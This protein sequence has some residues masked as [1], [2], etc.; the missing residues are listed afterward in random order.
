MKQEIFELGKDSVIYGV[1]SVA[2]RFVGLITL[3]LFTAYL[4]PEEYGVLAM[5]ALLGMVA[6]PVFSLGLSAAM[7][8]SYFEKDTISNKSKTVWSVF[9]INMLSVF[10]LIILAWSFPVLF[11]KFVRLPENYSFLVSLSLT[12][13]A[14]TILVTSF[15]QRIQFERQARLY[16]MITVATALAAILTSIYTVVFLGWGVYGMVYGQVAGNLITFLAFFAV[17]IR[18]TFPTISGRIIKDLLKLGLPFV[19]SFAFLFILMHVNKYILEWRYGLDAVGVYSIG[20]NLG[21][22][23]SIITGGITTAWFPFYMRY[24]DKQLEATKIFGKLFSYYIIGVGCLTLAFFIFARPMVMLLTN[25]AF[26]DSYMVVGLVASSLYFSG[27]YSFLLPGIYFN[28]E[29]PVQSLIQG[30]AVILSLPLTFIL[31]I[32]F[33]I[34]GAGLSVALG[35]FL[36]AVL[37]HFW[38]RFRRKNYLNVQYEWRRVMLFIAFFL[39]VACFYLFVKFDSFFESVV[40]SIFGMVLVVLLTIQFFSKS[41]M[42]YLPIIRLFKL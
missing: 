19:P 18:D 11:G 1:G 37:T 10:I 34:L 39:I 13:T 4:S 31:I 38:N 35:F 8:P 20:F 17:G 6:Q 2:T 36:T 9:A 5:L 21:M 3:P 40:F 27:I 24:I 23:M 12:G 42:A 22:A 30:V 28:K 32:Y 33:G 41:E 7:G 14:L 26:H 16:V 29:I 15:M 25:E